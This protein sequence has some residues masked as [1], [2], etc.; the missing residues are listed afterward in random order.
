MSP[1]PA[2]APPK[3]KEHE[4]LTLNLEQ[5]TVKANVPKPATIQGENGAFTIF[6]GNN[7]INIGVGRIMANGA[8]M[9]EIPAETKNLTLSLSDAGVLTVSRDGTPPAEF[10][11]PPVPAE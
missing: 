6:S 2:P 4:D 3:A 1:A 11:I 8:Q 7:R 9:T 5:R 10:K